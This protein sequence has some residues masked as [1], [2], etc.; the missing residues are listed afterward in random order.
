MVNTLE[1]PATDTSAAVE[2]ARRGDVATLRAWLDSGGD[3]DAY[4]ADG[5]TALLAGAVRGRVEVVELLLHG[6]RPANPDLRHARSGALPIHF[7]GHSGSVPVA[8]RLLAVRPDHL[9][10]VWLLNGHTLL[11]Q[12]VFYAHFDMAK[13]AVE[14]GANTAATSLRGL[15]PLDMAKQFQNQPL[16]RLLTPHD[17]PP[18]EK[19]AYYQTL[20]QRIA[21]VVSPQDEPAQ[22]LADALV[23]AIQDGLARVPT[24]SGVTEITLDRI[25]E[26]IEVRGADVNRLGGVL[27]QPPLVVIVTGNNGDPAIAA[28]AD[29]RL[30]VAGQ[31]LE[32]GADPLREEVHPMGADAVIRASV[33]NHL[34]ILRLM[35]RHTSP[36]NMTKALNRLPVVNGLTALHDTVLRASTAQPERLEGY[37][38]QIRWAVGCGARWDIE[39]FSGRTQRDIAEAMNPSPARR[40][41]LEALGVG[42]TITQ[43]TPR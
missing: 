37:L 41:I 9:D 2:A 13:F 8:E 17:R 3:P 10:D 30:R 26:L 27:R 15:T 21:P 1:T 24:D 31:L 4:D 23:A 25:R 11:L 6:P 42:T 33:F 38:A 40:R 22:Q 29:F 36:D 14:R 16:I 34:D 20:L 19:M 43:E 5:W 35:A 12:A 7:A 28:M 32:Y 39:D 18:A